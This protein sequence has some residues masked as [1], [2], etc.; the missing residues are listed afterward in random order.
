MY[1]M[2]YIRFLHRKTTWWICE[3]PYLVCFKIKKAYE[4]H[5]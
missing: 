5:A 1:D 2:I 4:M 3:H